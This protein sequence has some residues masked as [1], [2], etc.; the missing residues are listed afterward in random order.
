MSSP[1][2][3]TKLRI[4][5]S[6]G[7]LAGAAIANALFRQPHLDVHV[8]ESAA[9]FME[10]G[11]AVGIAINAQ[12]A[13]SMIVPDAEDLFQRAGAIPKSSTRIMIVGT[14]KPP[15]GRCKVVMRAARSST[16]KP[17]MSIQRIQ[18][19]GALFADSDA[20]VRNRAPGLP[21]EPKSLTSRRRKR[22]TRSTVRFY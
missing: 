22:V 6:G 12:R 13:L 20:D 21:Q 10:S 3:P 1:E 14:W 2:T 17:A 9:E 7:G 8:Y 11:Q 16:A 15:L 4:A 5:I 18:T 19:L